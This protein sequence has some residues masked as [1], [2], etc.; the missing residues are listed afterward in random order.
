MRSTQL[1]TALTNLEFT[2]KHGD[3]QSA[4]TGLG[5][6]G[7]MSVERILSELTKRLLNVTGTKWLLDDL[8]DRAN[9]NKDRQ[10]TGKVVLDRVAMV[11]SYLMEMHAEGTTVLLKPASL[12]SKSTM[13]TI[14]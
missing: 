13:G 7:G 11:L 3:T 8:T 12:P 14:I 6:V 2:V 4:G 9:I 5:N 10:L 1:S